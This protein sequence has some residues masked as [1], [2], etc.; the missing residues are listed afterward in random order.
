MPQTRA[1]NLLLAGQATAAPGVMGGMLSG[2]LACET[3]V[4]PERLRNKVKACR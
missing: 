4:G 3:I 2:F 1:E